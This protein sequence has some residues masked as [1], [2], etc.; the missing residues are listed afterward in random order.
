[1]GSQE[2]S[3]W[4]LIGTLLV[5]VIAL[6][7]NHVINRRAATIN[8]VI[9]QKNDS[10]YTTARETFKT[11]QEEENVAKYADKTQLES[12]IR[13]AILT[14]LNQYEFVASGINEGAF[15][16]GLYKRLQYGV[17]TKDYDK[18]EGFISELRRA[19][20]HPTLF[21]EFET[22]A[23]RFKKKPLKKRG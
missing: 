18:L 13:D 19:N 20:K 4:I 14:I 10:R 15:C 6:W 2:I 23:K 21:Q 9:H 11:L 3:N 12:D 5:A 7:R 22:L 1:M 16:K 17:V 8:M